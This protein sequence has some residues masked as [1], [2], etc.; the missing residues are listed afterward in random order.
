MCGTIPN[1]GHMV[2]AQICRR[3]ATAGD[4]AEISMDFRVSADTQFS[5][6]R[7]RAQTW[8]AQCEVQFQ[9]VILAELAHVWQRHMGHNALLALHDLQP[10]QL[11]SPL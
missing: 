6:A 4:T 2:E 8:A 9:I 3:V 5:R 10:A 1:G 11:S 7:R